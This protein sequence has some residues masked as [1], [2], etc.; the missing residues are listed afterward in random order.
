MGVVY[1]AEDLEVGRQVALKRIRPDRAGD[2]AR[3]RFRREAAVTG[4]LE[5]PGIVPVYTVGTDDNGEPYYVMRLIRGET[6]ADA[7]QAFHTARPGQALPSRAERN[8]QFRGLLERFVTVCLTVGYAHSKGVV[9]RDLKPGNISLGRFGETL[10]LD[11]GLAGFLKAPQPSA[12]AVMETL[13]V[14]VAEDCAQTRP[15]IAQGT[16]AYM[17]PEQANGQWDD[18]GPASDIFSLGA[19]LYHLLTDRPPYWGATALTDASLVRF[20]PPRHHKRDVPKALEAICLKALAADPRRRYASAEALAADVRRWLADEPVEARPDTL[21]TRLARWCRRHPAAVGISLA[22]LVTIVVALMIGLHAVNAEKQETA[23]ASGEAISERNRALEAEEKADRKAKDEERERKRAEGEKQRADDRAEDLRQ[24]LALSRTLL[25]DKAWDET[26]GPHALDLLDQVPPELRGFEWGYRRR[27]FR[28]G[29]F[30]LHGHTDGLTGT[31]FSPDGQLLAT[32]SVDQSARLWDARSGELLLTLEGHA[33]RVSGVAFSPDG[34]CLATASWDGSVR[35]WDVDS[36]EL[37][38]T[39]EGHG[40]RVSSVAFSPDGKRLA[41]AS[42]DLTARL[43]DVRSGELLL[44][45]QGHRGAVYGVAFSPDGEC[46]ATASADG[47]SRLWDAGSGEQL[48]T[49]QGHTG[50]VAGVAWG[51]DGRRLATASWDTTA[52]VW[53][54]ST[55]ELLLTLREHSDAVLGVAWSPDGQRLATTSLDQTSR[56]WDLSNGQRLLTLKGHTG[57]VTGAAWSPDGQRLVTASRDQTGRL[58]ETRSGQPFLTLPGHKGTVN[59]VAFSPDGQRLATGSKDQTVRLWD[60]ANGALLRTFE[61]HQGEVTCVAFSPDGRF[62]A[63]GSWDNTLRLWDVDNG[64]LLHT[65]RGHTERIL[66]V[67]FSQ[68]GQ[69]LATA[70]WDSTVGLWDARSGESLG[71]IPHP[72]RVWGV[73]FSPDGQRLVTT[74]WDTLVRLWHVPSGKPLLTP[75]KGHL[76]P[77][78]GVVFST[79]GRYFATA[80]HD[81][82]A[83]VWDARNGKQLLTL[84]GHTQGVLGVAFSADGQRLATVSWDGTARLWDARSGELL[85]TLEG[86]TGGVH[87]VAFS[88]DGLTLAT[89]SYDRTALLWDAHSS[90][91]LRVLKGHKQGVF[92]AAFSRDGQRLATGSWDSTTRVWD[93]QTGDLLLTLTGHRGRV[94]SVAFDPNGLLIATAAN[95]RTA[96]LWNARSGELLH[97]L[98]GHTDAVTRVGFSPDG[99]LL[100]TAS[101]DQTMRL[102][103]VRTGQEVPGLPDFPLSENRVSPDGRLFALLQADVVR[104]LGRELTDPERHGRTWATRFD[105][106]WHLGEAVRHEQAGL[107][108]A[109][110]F[111]YQQVLW[112]EPEHVPALAGLVRVRRWLPGSPEQEVPLLERLLAARPADVGAWRQLARV[113]A[114]ST[115]EAY[116]QTCLRLRR[117]AQPETALAGCVGLAAP[118]QGLPG[119]LLAHLAF[120]DSATRSL[121][122]VAARLCVLRPDAVEDFE[123]L[124]PLVPPDDLLTRGA[125]LCRA[126]KHADAIE[127]LLEAR[128]EA[129]WPW[130][131]LAYLG[132][133]KRAE[134]RQELAMVAE[135]LAAPAPDLPGKPRQTNAERLPRDERQELDL[136]RLEVE[137]ALAGPTSP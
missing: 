13:P 83:R 77:V 75:L 128:S 103:D 86:H 59:S 64:Q 55:G 57:P 107:W 53:A 5:H 37:L 16:P 38:L 89:G 58:W 94:N 43:W 27:L 52:R 137:K 47:T 88:P 24:Q 111:H 106:A 34:R 18:V 116:R 7:I 109:G 120:T 92:S 9:H 121:R 44:A 84:K 63:A 87:S 93:P 23:R 108:F 3:E 125:V 2:A 105:P 39:L 67:A 69:R 21:W 76:G 36:G 6:L 54:S 132:Q 131:A 96:R 72:E 112:N 40:D 129:R 51:P 102:W 126:G 4:R 11:W 95:D 42:W 85:L 25:S 49:F 31:A 19:T 91:P 99:R 79:D 101:D 33:D 130:L 29:I 81:N 124:L 133:G 98:K 30:T 15:G 136:L 123:A 80:S 117:L 17:S 134:A 35:L 14:K 119:A 20:D 48:L 10:V 73:A 8:L 70:S 100:G 22:T 26:N 122:G 56:L 135:W 104:L 66:S 127:A 61:G 1:R 50:P 74:S 118:M 113:Q 71:S 28:G 90:E 65:F 12:S 97:V 32:A 46:L 78:T 82:T 60:V 41:T 114:A 68:D 110:A 115:P 45:L 62:L